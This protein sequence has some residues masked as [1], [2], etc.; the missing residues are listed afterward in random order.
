L[1]KLLKKQ[2]QSEMIPSGWT[3]LYRQIAIKYPNRVTTHSGYDRGH[4][5]PSAD[6]TNT[7]ENNSATF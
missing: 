1:L 4:Y 7:S 5:C 2:W 6:R 3:A